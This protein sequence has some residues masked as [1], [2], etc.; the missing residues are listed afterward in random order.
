ML[1]AK[2]A[3]IVGTCRRHAWSIIALAAVLAF[4]SGIYTS[5]HFVIDTDINRLISPDLPW[6][7]QELAFSGAFPQRD[8]TIFAVVDAPTTELASQAGRALAERLSGQK[9]LFRA[10]AEPQN[11]QLFVRDGLLFLAT[12][13][14]ERSLGGL[15]QAQ[16]LLQTLVTDPN[17]RGFQQVLSLGLTGV[18]VKRIT[19]DAMTTIL[20]MAAVAVE[21]VLAGR[22]SSFSWQEMFQFCHP[23]RFAGIFHCYRLK[24]CSSQGVFGVDR[25]FCAA[26][27]IA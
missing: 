23:L 19:L 14:L 20:S 22:P 2:L 21:N 4:V 27:W 26:L 11:S 1:K 3:F 17:L 16:P 15:T 13:E 7:Q 18:Q 24:N 25:A 9:D 5:R 10:V 6:R 12:D 8:R